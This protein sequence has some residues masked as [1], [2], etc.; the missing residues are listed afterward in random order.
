MVK[1]VKLDGKAYVCRDQHEVCWSRR[2]CSATNII[3]MYGDG[4]LE[5]WYWLAGKR[6]MCFEVGGI[7]SLLLW[8]YTTNNGN[9]NVT[10]YRITNE[11][12][13]KTIKSYRNPTV[14]DVLREQDEQIQKL[15][16]YYV[17]NYEGYDP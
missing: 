4:K 2:S 5:D 3:V 17:E 16:R 14:E 13:L 1:F 15:L 9:T 8:A 6:R 7:P 10:I 12:E 11:G